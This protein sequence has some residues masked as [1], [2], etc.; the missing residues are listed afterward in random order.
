MALV[1]KVIKMEDLLLW[2]LRLLAGLAT[3]VGNRGTRALIAQN[4]L[5]GHHCR[6]CSAPGGEC[7]IS[8]PPTGGC[9]AYVRGS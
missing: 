2:I 1:G 5:L 9:S 7:P 6:F 3:L 4:L 8:T